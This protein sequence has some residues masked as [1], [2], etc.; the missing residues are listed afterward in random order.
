MPTLR[1]GW[2]QFDAA[3]EVIADGCRDQGLCGV[4]GIPRGGLQLAV[5]VSHRIALP[6]VGAGGAGTLIVDD[7]H[8]SGLTL[9]RW[10]QRFPLSRFAVWVTREDEPVNYFAALAGIG[11]DWICFPW[12][13]P[14]R[15]EQDMQDYRE[16]M[17]VSTTTI[18]KIRSGEIWK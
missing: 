17:T 9:A 5:A 6:L 3:A 12:E 1:L 14:D 10:R 8:D 18:Q 7:I 2:P 11:S 16:A 15:A 4:C 13:D